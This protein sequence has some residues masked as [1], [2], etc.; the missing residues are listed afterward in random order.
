M[1]LKRKHLTARCNDQVARPLWL[2]VCKTG[3]SNMAY[4]V[5]CRRYDSVMTLKSAVNCLGEGPTWTSV[6]TTSI[7]HIAFTL[8]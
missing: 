8:I 3:G 5:T 6:F 7:I 4:R 2:A 1:L